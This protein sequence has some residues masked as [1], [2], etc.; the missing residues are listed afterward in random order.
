MTLD[1][2]YIVEAIAYISTIYG[3]L[4][5]REPRKMQSSRPNPRGSSIDAL[6]VAISLKSLEG[7]LDPLG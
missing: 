7:G 1:G 3:L 5:S 2:L 4:E 6:I